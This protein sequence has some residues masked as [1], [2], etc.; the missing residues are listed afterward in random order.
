[1]KSRRWI[2]GLLA[3]AVAGAWGVLPAAAKTVVGDMLPAPDKEWSAES[4]MTPVKVEDG[5][6]LKSLATQAGGNAV[7]YFKNTYHKG[8]MIAYDFTV[9]G[10]EVTTNIGFI[11]GLEENV[12]I[13]GYWIRGI[14]STRAL[15][16]SSTLPSIW[17]ANR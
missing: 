10:D 11:R 15:I 9:D 5:W 1:M 17:A 8:Q 7:N 6:K 16:S 4:T 3:A 13:K 12:P 14:S 2:C